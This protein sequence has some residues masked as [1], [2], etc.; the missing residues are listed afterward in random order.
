M[1]TLNFFQKKF[2]SFSGKSIMVG[3]LVFSQLGI[4]LPPIVKGKELSLESY[5]PLSFINPKDKVFN[6]QQ[7]SNFTN[8][9]SLIVATG[10][11]SALVSI[12]VN[13]YLLTTSG[14][15]IGNRNYWK[16]SRTPVASMYID[17]NTYFAIRFNTDVVPTV[18]SRGTIYTTTLPD[19]TTVVARPFSTSRP[20]A[21]TLEIQ[22]PTGAPYKVRYLP[23]K[24]CLAISG[25]LIKRVTDCY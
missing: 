16:N 4:V 14:G 7:Y 12:A 3:L 25:N 5:Q 18:D 13:E 9:S 11:N 15:P 1:G 22:R 6:H 23:P 17:F 21:P 24:Q 8:N 2:R 20:N 10:L 19:G